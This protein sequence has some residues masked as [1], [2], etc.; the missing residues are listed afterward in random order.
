[1]FRGWMVALFL[2]LCLATTGCGRV[3]RGLSK[4]KWQNAA[5][6]ARKTPKPA[7]V[8]PPAGAF[9]TAA[10]SATAIAAEQTV[11]RS[12]SQRL[13]QVLAASKSL[14]PRLQSLKARIPAHVYARLWQEWQRNDA[15][16][17]AVNRQLSEGG[18]SAER[19]QR[20]E[21]QALLLEQKHAEIERLAAEWG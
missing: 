19:R 15:E 5:K 11:A 7:P 12:I 1:M 13:P 14:G 17:A 10:K 9:P 2:V 8:K 21:D 18:L 16:L 20:L 3:V 6:V 4:V